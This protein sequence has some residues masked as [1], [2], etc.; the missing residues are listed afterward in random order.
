MPP[1]KSVRVDVP[2][3]PEEKEALINEKQGEI[4]GFQNLLSQ[5]DYIVRKCLDEVYRMLG[6]LAPNI[7]TPVYDEYRDVETKAQ[8]FRDRINVLQEEIEELKS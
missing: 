1:K 8:Q 4:N 6:V 5:K 2:L 3:T 7:A